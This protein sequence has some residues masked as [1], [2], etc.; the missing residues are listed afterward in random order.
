MPTVRNNEVFAEALGKH[1]WFRK[2]YIFLTQ[3]LLLKNSII[4]R[5]IALC[6]KR[7]SKAQHVLYAG[8]GLGQLLSLFARMPNKYNV[9]AIDKNSR[10]VVESSKYYRAEDIKNIYCRTDNIL[11]FKRP[12]TFDLCLAI[13]LLNYIEDDTAALRNLFECLKHPG[14]LLI[15]NSSDYSDERANI[16]NPIYNDIR[17]RR[18]YSPSELRS[19]LKEVGFSKVKGRYVYGRPGIMSWKLTTGFPSYW[20]RVSKLFY[21]LLPLYT[22]ICIP[23]VLLLNFLDI[24]F[25]HKRGK[26]VVL[27]AFK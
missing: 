17:Y 14:M 24:T 4:R 2:F 3:S 23:F 25:D 26:C 7:K 19:K 8:F 27:K 9:L 20:I 16:I 15:F 18:G 5:E 12:E 22:L 10:M 1:S 11:T 13:N 21:I 6:C